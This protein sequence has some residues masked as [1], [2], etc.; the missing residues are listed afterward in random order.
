VGAAIVGV[1]LLVAFAAV[2]CV[3]LL[4]AWATRHRRDRLIATTGHHAIGRVLAVGSDDDG[5]GTLGRGGPPLTQ[6]A[7]MVSISAARPASSSRSAGRT[8]ESWRT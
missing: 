3:V 1:W 8:V 7:G 4:P 2:L 6:P 5:M